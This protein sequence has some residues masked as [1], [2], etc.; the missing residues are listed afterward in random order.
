[1]T[2]AGIRYSQR[3]GRIRS[4]IIPDTDRE[5]NAIILRQGE[6]LL[7]LDPSSLPI[8]DG[9]PDFR[10]V[11]LRLNA[12]TGKAPAREDHYVVIDD[13]NGD[14]LGAIVADPDCGDSV[15]SGKTLI[16]RDDAKELLGWMDKDGVLQRT[17]FVDG[18]PVRVAE[19]VLPPKP[20]DADGGV[21]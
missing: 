14:V 18:V 20:D 4:I 17:R 15:P 16:Q 19:P 12:I 8:V 2:K 5:L 10:A 7:K 6:A 13:R 9:R 21:R 3:T 1:M 11:Q